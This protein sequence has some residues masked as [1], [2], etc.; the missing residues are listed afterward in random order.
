MDANQLDFSGLRASDFSKGV[1]STKPFELPNL[2]DFM[3]H[4]TVTTPLNPNNAISVRT[5]VFN[6]D[7]KPWIGNFRRN[8]LTLGLKAYMGPGTDF[9]VNFRGTALILP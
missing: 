7:L 6:F 4:G 5:D 9:P 2:Q 1:G 8:T 3:V